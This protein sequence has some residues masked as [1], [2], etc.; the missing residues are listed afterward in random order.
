MIFLY[1]AE[2]GDFFLKN[3]KKTL[4]WNHGLSS[5]IV[6]SFDFQSIFQNFFWKSEGTEFEVRFCPRRAAY[7][8]FYKIDI[9][10]KT[11]FSEKTKID[12]DQS[13]DFQSIF[14][15]KKL[16]LSE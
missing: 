4:V 6:Q 13:F 15:V 5:T 16:I 10:L 1:A 2:G 11:S 14:Q 8:S 9:S 12:V 7:F 3:L